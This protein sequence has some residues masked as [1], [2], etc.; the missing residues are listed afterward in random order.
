MTDQRQRG[1]LAVRR[2]PIFG[3]ASGAVP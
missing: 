3:W 2:S 1:Q